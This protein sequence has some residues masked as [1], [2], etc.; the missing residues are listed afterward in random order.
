MCGAAPLTVFH[1]ADVTWWRLPA[2]AGLVRAD[3]VTAE[4]AR[5]FDQRAE[6]KP[7]WRR[8]FKCPR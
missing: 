6:R 2:G 4:F 3:T 7:R 8:H 1:E 5:M